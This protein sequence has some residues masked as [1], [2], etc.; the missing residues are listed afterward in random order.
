RHVDDDGERARGRRARDG[1]PE[2]RRGERDDEEQ[3]EYEER[4]GRQ[5][6][7]GGGRGDGEE[8]DGAGRPEDGH[9]RLTN[10]AAARSPATKAGTGRFVAR[11]A[12]TASCAVA[13]ARS[14]AS[15]AATSVRYRARTAGVTAT[16]C[17]APVSTS[18][19]SQRP[20][21]PGSRSRAPSTWRSA[22]AWRPARSA[23][24]PGA[25]AAG[26]TMKSETTTVAAGRRSQRAWAAIAAP[27]SRAPPA[28][29]RAS[30]AATAR[31]LARW[32]HTREGSGA[33]SPG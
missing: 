24:R 7:R 29:A 9:R 26:S 10:P 11:R 3:L 32:R 19:S 2:V 15:C 27:R 6:A 31:A 30:H 16:G 18:R 23:A 4:V 5:A 13:S 22:T 17:V 12:K 14:A 8:E 33:R 21:A 25:S 1:G 20:T 28:G